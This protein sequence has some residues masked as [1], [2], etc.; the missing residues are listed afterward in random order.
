ML[1]QHFADRGQCRNS[2]TSNQPYGAAYGLAHTSLACRQCS[3]A[4]QPQ[5]SCLPKRIFIG[6]A[7]SPPPSF[8]TLLNP[9]RFPGDILQPTPSPRANIHTRLLWS[10]GQDQKAKCPQGQ[11]GNKDEV[12]G[13]GQTGDSMPCLK[14]AAVTQLPAIA[15]CPECGPD[16]ANSFDTFKRS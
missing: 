16:V 7:K 13:M 15:A 2:V 1:S 5:T 3:E 12:G 4:L 10:K 14:E 11:V 6:A 9:K 8:K